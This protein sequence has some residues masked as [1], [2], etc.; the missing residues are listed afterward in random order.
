MVLDSVKEYLCGDVADELIESATIF[1]DDYIGDGYGKQNEAIK[2]TIKNMLSNHGIPMDSTYT[3]KAYTGM[4][5]YI[6]NKR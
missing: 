6:E 1:I 5:D 4:M 3:A 2:T